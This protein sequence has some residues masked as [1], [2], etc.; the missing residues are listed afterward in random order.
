MIL[1]VVDNN[2]NL[3]LLIQ[4]SLVTTGLYYGM[5]GIFACAG[6]ILLNV[7][8]FDLSYCA[9]SI[10]LLF[11]SATGWLSTVVK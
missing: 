2:I 4:W 5:L 3:L 10:I 9:L 7:C 1:V 6:T 11:C 8:Y